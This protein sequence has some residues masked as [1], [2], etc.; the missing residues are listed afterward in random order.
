MGQP[1][2]IF[3]FERWIHEP[4]KEVHPKPF[5]YQELHEEHQ[6]EKYQLVQTKSN[7][8]NKRI[9]VGPQEGYLSK[10]LEFYEDQ[11]E[12]LNLSDRGVRKL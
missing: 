8:D 9:Y 11:E 6:Q 1:H 5:Q 2:E 7:H 10:K 3:H 12:P 4:L